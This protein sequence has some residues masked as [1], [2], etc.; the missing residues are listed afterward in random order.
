MDKVELE[1]HVAVEKKAKKD[2]QGIVEGK[3]ELKLNVLNWDFLNLGKAEIVGKTS[4]STAKELNRQDIHTIKLTLVPA[5]KDQ[6][7][8]DK[9]SPKEKEDI[10]LATKD[11]IFRGE[12]A[13]MRPD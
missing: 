10:I 5:Y 2:T 12:S 1:I 13:S 7:F 8:M 11:S 9:L 6:I 4:D 3:A